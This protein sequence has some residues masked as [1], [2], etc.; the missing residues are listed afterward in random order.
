M[1][2]TVP[3]STQF[4]SKMPKA[5]AEKIKRKIFPETAAGGFTSVDGTIEFYTR[6]NALIDEDMVVLD[7]GAGRGSWTDDNVAYRR[8]L[9]NFKGKVKKVAGV[10]IDPAVS[11]NPSLDEAVVIKPEEALPFPD[12]TFD[13]IISDYTFEHIDEPFQMARELDRVLKPGGWLCARTPNRFGY[14]ALGAILTPN[15]LHGAI[16]RLAQPSRQEIDIH[17]TRYKLNT[18]G[19]LKKLFPDDKYDRYVYTWEPEPAYM[20]NSE[21]I[22]RTTLLLQRFLP[23]KLRPVLMIFMQK[24]TMPGRNSSQR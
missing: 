23:K 3:P 19:K 7:F 20:G 13:L 1:A 17:P 18:F 2:E 8:E 21:I 6:V 9:R 14:I 12:H 22:W 5:D 11:C 15:R 16:L 10:D 4:R 24:R